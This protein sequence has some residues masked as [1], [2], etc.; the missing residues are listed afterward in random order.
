MKYVLYHVFYAISKKV[1][2]KLNELMDFRH[3]NEN[4]YL[5]QINT[6]IK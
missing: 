1:M 5:N 4:T 2:L 3:K 6:F